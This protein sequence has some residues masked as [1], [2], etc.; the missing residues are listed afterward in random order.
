[1]LVSIKSGDILDQDVEVIVNPWNRNIIPWWMLIPQGVSKAIK[2][3]GGLEPFR[4]V[5]KYGSIPLGEARYTSAGNL[6]FDGIIHVAG[7]NLFWCAT[8]FSI[9]QSVI[10]TIEIVNNRNIKS[11]AF[12][13]IGSGSGNRSRDLSLKIMK[14]TFETIDSKATVII[15]KY[16]L[17]KKESDLFKG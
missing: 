10:N 9:S 8:R 2:R 3:K 1:M 5:G 11:I 7:I 14:E 15:V 13:L 17:N 6:P 4:E 16:N 12:P